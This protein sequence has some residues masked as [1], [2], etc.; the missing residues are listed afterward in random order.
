MEFQYMASRADLYSPNDIQQT[1]LSDFTTD[2]A[3]NPVTGFLAKVNNEQ[4]AKQMLRNLILTNVGERFFQ[5]NVGSK[6]YNLL[7]EPADGVV[8]SML[9]DTISQTIRNHLPFIN[10]IGVN[11]TDRADYNAY[12]IS[13][14]FSIIN[15]IN[16]V[17]LDIVLK[18][19]R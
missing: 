13:I 16:P 18:R 8:M 14:V 15:N 3:R 11:I 12:A 1:Y 9:Q 7:F 10:L 4:D 5:P 6:I 19:V 2:F 17:S